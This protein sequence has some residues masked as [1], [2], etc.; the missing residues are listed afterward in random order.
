[1]AAQDALR[2][3]M[4]AETIRFFVQDFTGLMDRDTTVAGRIPAL[5]VG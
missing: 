4:E 1:M 5:P 3:R 2:A